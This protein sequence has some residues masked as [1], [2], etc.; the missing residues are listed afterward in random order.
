MSSHNNVIPYFHGNISNIWSLFLTERTRFFNSMKAVR[1]CTLAF[2]LFVLSAIP[3][4]GSAQI[5]L[6][7]FDDDFCD[8]GNLADGFDPG[9]G[10]WTV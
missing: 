8:A 7:D 10:A 6:E 3:Q 5:Y 2:T 9:N 1:F 4:S